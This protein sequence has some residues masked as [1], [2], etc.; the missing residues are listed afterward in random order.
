M[1]DYS[2]KITPICCHAYSVNRLQEEAENRWVNRLAIVPQTFCD[3]KEIELKTRKIQQKNQQCV[4]IM[5]SRLA[6]KKRLLVDSKLNWNEH[7]KYVSAKASRSLNFLRHRLYN[8]S[9]S[10]KSIAYKCIVRPVLEYACPEWHL[11]SNTIW[12]PYN[13]RLP[14]GLPIVGGI[15]YHIAGVNLLMTVCKS[16]TSLPSSSATSISPFAMYMIVCTTEALFLFTIIFSY[17]KPQLDL[18]LYRSGQLYL[19][20]IHIA[21]LF[22]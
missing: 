10:I 20:L 6:N 22:L 11:Y 3:L 18:I 7:C 14:I 4:T 16:Y 19:L 9:I 15:H 17:L 8:Y 12:N 2:R 1:S 21:S 5:Q 13:I